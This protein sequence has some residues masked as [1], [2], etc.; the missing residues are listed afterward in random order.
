MI[1]ETQTDF[2][3]AN[4]DIKKIK[5]YLQ[6]KYSLNSLNLILYSTQYNNKWL[7][8]LGLIVVNK[9]KR[10][11]LYGSTAIKEIIKFCKKEDYSLVLNPA[12]IENNKYTLKNLI[13]FYKK[14]GFKKGGPTKGD[15][16]IT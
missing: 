14:L 9:E 5:A 11:L 1:I 10:N 2:D 7:L 8:R 12:K 3:K 4:Q 6:S 13:D 16:I 15:L